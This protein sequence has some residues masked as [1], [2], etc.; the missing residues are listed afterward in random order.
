MRTEVIARPANSYDRV[1]EAASDKQTRTIQLDHGPLVFDVWGSLEHR[2]TDEL[3][4]LLIHGW[5]GTGS[6]WE[7]TAATL[8]KSVPVI[9]PDLPGTGR[10]QPVAMAQNMFDQVRSLEALL[11]TLQV[12]KIQVVGHSMGSAMALLLADSQRGRVQRLVLTALSFFVTEFE[13]QI[14]R[15]VMRVFRFSMAFRPQWLASVPGMAQLMAHRYFYRVPDDPALLKQGL[16]DYLQLDAG[17]AAACADDAPAK[18]IPEAG[19]RLQIP[20]L[21]VACRQD[22]VMPPHNVDYTANI[23]PDCEVVWIDECGHMPMLEKPHAY[24]AILRDFLQL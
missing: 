8:S 4:L 23:I 1:D 17:T 6:Y 24:L 11:D 3:P 12:E 20:T 14:Y 16:V 13:K 18:A 15:T 19:S 5:G 21:L 7:S 10:S 9:V 22:R 2:S